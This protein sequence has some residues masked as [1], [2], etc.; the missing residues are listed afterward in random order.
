MKSARVLQAER[1]E[2]ERLLAQAEAAQR[3]RL[4]RVIEATGLLDVKFDEAALIAAISSAMPEVQGRGLSTYG[5]RRGRLNALDLKITRA[6]I[7][8]RKRETRLEILLGGWLIAQFQRNPERLAEDAP[9][10]LA[11]LAAGP[12]GDAG[13]PTANVALIENLLASLRPAAPGAPAPKPLSGKNATRSQI[14]LGAWIIH[15]AAA[16]PAWLEAVAPSVEAF[17]ATNPSQS[18]RRAN[19]RVWSWWRG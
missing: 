17:I 6:R 1:L 16:D 15:R 13:A 9:P 5:K 8:D 3:A 14:L 11:Y 12:A 10:L 4:E 19:Q 7:A 18:L 2:L